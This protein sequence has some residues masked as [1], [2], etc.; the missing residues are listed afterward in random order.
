MSGS[1]I[2]NQQINPCSKIINT[3]P[4]VSEINGFSW[5]S[6][7]Y[8]LRLVPLIPWGIELMLHGCNYA[9]GVLSLLRP[10]IRDLWQSSVTLILFES[11]PV[12]NLCFLFDL[13]SFWTLTTQSG[14]AQP[15]WGGY[16]GSCPV[17]SSY[18]AWSGKSHRQSQ[19]D[20]HHFWACEHTEHD[21]V[22]GMGQYS[23]QTWCLQMWATLIE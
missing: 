20:R 2:P 4:W 23:R 13:N 16:A 12:K 19:G 9:L 15:L 5:M 1:Q 14:L 18:D 6:W 17:S 10:N 21:R 11:S 3:N 22:P 7:W 8:F